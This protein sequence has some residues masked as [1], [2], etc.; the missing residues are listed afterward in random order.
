MVQSS[1]VVTKF[2]RC[3]FLLKAIGFLHVI[4]SATLNDCL[5]RTCVSENVVQK[6]VGY[7]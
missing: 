2:I 1:W 4:I 5:V 6:L 7:K 3:V